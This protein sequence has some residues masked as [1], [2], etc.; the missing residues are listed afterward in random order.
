[1]QPDLAQIPAWTDHYFLRTK[2]AVQRFGD[3]RVTYAVF[4]RRPVIAAPRLAVDWLKEVAAARGAA[5]E[6]EVNYDEG[7]WVGRDRCQIE[8]PW[9]FSRFDIR[10]GKAVGGPATFDE[11]PYE[12][13]VSDSG[14]VEVRAKD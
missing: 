13:R 12:T 4:M 10:T 7:K 3:V 8:C 11:I 5:V 1:M 14:F 6:I 2:Q 9:H